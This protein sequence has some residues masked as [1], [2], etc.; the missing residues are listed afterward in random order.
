MDDNEV[1]DSVI[2]GA[3]PA[4]LTAAL[5]MARYLRRP[6]VLHDGTARAA[7]I[8]ESFNV[9]GF[10]DGISG[11]DLLA[12]MTRQAGQYGA[13]LVEGKLDR[14]ERVGGGFV[15]HAADG[16]RWQTRS[17]ILATGIKLHQVDM[18][19]D[20][21]EAAIRAGVLRYCPICD[22]FEYRDKRIVV[23]G[24][25]EQGAAEALFMRHFSA[26]ITLV[27][28]AYSELDDATRAAL[29][30]AGITVIERRIARYAPGSEAMVI[31][32]EGLAEPLSFELMVPGLGVTPRSELAGQLGVGINDKGCCDENAL[33]DSGVPGLWVAGDVLEGLDQVSA[34]IGH[35]AIA[36]TKAHNWLREQDG[37]TL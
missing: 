11:A 9:P 36:A 5:Y 35:G 2:V 25:D 14:A 19:H 37:E 10:P 13:R 15:L 30:R 21:H 28:R 7:R 22:G 23:V 33:F 16:R 4:G 18:P 29:K 31:H 17:L 6:L 12:R 3:G 32:L 34:A 26:N 1:Q 8:P 27:P 24:C 20:L